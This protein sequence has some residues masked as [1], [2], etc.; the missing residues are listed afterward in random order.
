MIK[1]KIQNKKNRIT[2]SLHDLEYNALS[3]IA[4]K[5]DVSLSWLV[6]KAVTEYLMKFKEFNQIKLFEM[7]EN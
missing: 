1:K 2:V 7:P 3:I 4:S 5:E 6:R